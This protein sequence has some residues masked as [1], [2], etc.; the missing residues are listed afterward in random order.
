MMTG[1]SKSCPSAHFL[2][3]AGYDVEA[4]SS[5]HQ[6]MYLAQHPLFLQFPALEEDIA[7]PDFVW[8]S[9]PAPDGVPEYQPPGNESGII[10]NV[11]AGNGSEG[12]VSPAH[13]VCPL[14][15][16][17]LLHVILRILTSTATRRSWGASVCGSH[18]QK[19]RITCKH[20]SAEWPKMASSNTSRTHPPYPSYDR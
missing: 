9:P 1:D 18:L 11:W 17:P 10:V 2:Q 8:S 6:P 19:C 20:T 15:R 4:Q 13:T 16:R 14:P 7:I 5:L 12:I 3:S